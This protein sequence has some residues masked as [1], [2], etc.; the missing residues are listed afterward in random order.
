MQVYV[1]PFDVPSY[2]LVSS[3][4]KLGGGIQRQSEAAQSGKTGQRRTDFFG[5]KEVCLY[6]L[7]D[8]YFKIFAYY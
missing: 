2:L 7:P 8:L 1:Q 4:N 5:H 6:K 3:L